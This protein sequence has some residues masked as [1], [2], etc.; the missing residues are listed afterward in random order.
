MKTFGLFMVLF[1]IT[2]IT[3]SLLTQW[4]SPEVITASILFAYIT[5]QYSTE[6]F[7]KK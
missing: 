6:E 7:K 5:Q 1:L 3:L 4:T 2:T